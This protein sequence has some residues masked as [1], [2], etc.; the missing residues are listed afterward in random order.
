MNVKFVFT[1]VAECQICVVL[2]VLISLPVKTFFSIFSHSIPLFFPL[3]LFLGNCINIRMVWP[4]VGSTNMNGFFPPIYI[5]PFSYNWQNPDR[6]GRLL[7]SQRSAVL[8]NI[9]KCL[10][11]Q[12][13]HI[14]WN[15]TS[16]QHT[17][18]LGEF[19]LPYAVLFIKIHFNIIFRSMTIFNWLIIPRDLSMSE[20][21]CNSL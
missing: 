8:W 15:P 13:L 6:F 2:T 21:L 9:N 19:H 1:C 3:F 11:T 16:S 10:S 5:G 18:T 4:H 20:A 17:T 14:L 7:A 12:I